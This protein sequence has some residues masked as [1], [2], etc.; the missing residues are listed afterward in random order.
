[1]MC[2]KTCGCLPADVGDRR[3]RRSS[4]RRR[5]RRRCG[6]GRRCCGR[7]ATPASKATPAARLCC[8][9]ATWRR[10]ETPASVAKPTAA[11]T[12]W[13]AAGQRLAP[14]TGAHFDVGTSTL[15]PPASST[16]NQQIR[17][18]PPPLPSHTSSFFFHSSTSGQGRVRNGDLGSLCLFFVDFRVQLKFRRVTNQFT[19]RQSISTAEPIT[20]RLKK[21]RMPPE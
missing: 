7:A 16:T 2:S 11:E 20:R 4:K 3:P 10:P 1:M 9:A 18:A 15:E 12:A 6:P 8:A 19:R 17:N 5:G 13:T 21:K 14:T